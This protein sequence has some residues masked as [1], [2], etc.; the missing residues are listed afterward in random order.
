MKSLTSS[1]PSRLISKLCVY[2]YNLLREPLAALHA[3]YLSLE[4]KKHCLKGLIWQ[5]LQRLC[6]VNNC[7]FFV[8]MAIKNGKIIEKRV[9]AALAPTVD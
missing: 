7:F 1:H 2:V 5:A 8:N 9:N 4:L 3:P 6:K